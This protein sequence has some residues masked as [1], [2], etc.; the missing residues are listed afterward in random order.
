[1]ISSHALLAFN[2]LSM[3]GLKLN[4]VIERAPS[5]KKFNHL[6]DIGPGPWYHIKCLVL[7]TTGRFF[8]SS[9]YG[10]PVVN[11]DAISFLSG[12]SRPFVDTIDDAI[13]TT[14]SRIF[15]PLWSLKRQNPP[16]KYGD[17]NLTV[18]TEI[19]HQTLLEHSSIIFW[20]A[21]MVGF[22]L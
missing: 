22:D 17:W 3:L 21:G 19:R 2:Y 12:D 15:M 6:V 7:I 18:I 8:S 13:L 16:I 14:F 4:P 11:Y 20:Q 5:A 10:D 1:M 9:C